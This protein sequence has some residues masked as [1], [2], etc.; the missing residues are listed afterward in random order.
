MQF[1]QNTIS[2]YL[3]WFKCILVEQKFLQI[4]SLSCITKK[5]SNFK[6]IE[7]NWAK[8]KHT[9]GVQKDAKQD[10]GAY[11]DSIWALNSNSEPFL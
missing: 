10:F 4:T 7:I 8:S 6:E 5:G 2:F 1:W 3:D 9:Y 11:E